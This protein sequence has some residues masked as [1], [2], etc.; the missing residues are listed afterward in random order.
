MKK[1]LV[2]ASKIVR[3]N[4]KNQN[5]EAPSENAGALLKK[6]DLED[7]L[8]KENKK[9]HRK[10]FGAIKEMPAS[11]INYFL[12]FSVFEDITNTTRLLAMFY[13]VF[14]QPADFDIKTLIFKAF[15]EVISMLNLEFI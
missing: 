10:L 2:V 5:L 13:T 6:I 3:T 1:E 9:I 12:K 11:Q 8:S 4:K 15:V 14:K 7:V